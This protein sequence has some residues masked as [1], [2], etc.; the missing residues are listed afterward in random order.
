MATSYIGAD[1][2]CNTT[3]LAVRRGG[4]VVDR[5]RVPTTIPALREVLGHIPNPKRMTFEEG[6]LADWLYRNVRGCVKELVV[7]D[8][9]RNRLI[10]ADGDKT[11][12]MDAEKLA[13]LLQGGH[14]R[15]VHHSD[16]AKRVELKQWVALYHDRVEDAVRQVNKIRARCRMYGVRPVRGFLRNEGMRER[17]LS[18]LKPAALVGQLRVLFLGYQAAAEQ[19]N[20]CRKELARRGRRESI[21]GQWQQ[22]PGIALIRAV[23]YLAYMDTP[24]RFGSRK[25]RW[26]YCGVGLERKASGTDAGGRDKPGRLRV[27][28][29]CNRRLK[30]VVLGAVLSALAQGENKFSLLYERLVRDGVSVGN[31]RR[32]TARKLIDTMTSMWKNGSDFV[33]DLA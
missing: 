12:P 11:N 1:V 2:D 30:N 18:G 10:V 9:R 17:W 13:E 21:V 25:K 26:K 3:V 6:P 28:R 32:A 8:P 22:L 7:C 31:A 19:V 16:S 33:P 20:R 14:L 5:Y 15:A 29:A 24:W 23:T 4:K 27:C